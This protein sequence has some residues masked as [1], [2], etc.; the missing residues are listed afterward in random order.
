MSKP[1][2][3]SL[4]LALG[5]DCN[6]DCGFCLQLRSDKTPKLDFS[7]VEKIMAE[8]M[9]RRDVKR[10]TLTGGEPTY[11]PYLETTLKIVKLAKEL[12]KE[13]CIFTNGTLLT[14][15][16]LKEFKEAGLTRFRVSL[17]D[18][19]D[20]DSVKVLMKRFKHYGLPAMAK[21]TVTK[22]NI[23]RLMNV[24]FHIPTSG[25]EWFQI[26]PYNRVE[27][28]EV[29]EKYELSPGQ[30]RYLSEIMLVF[31]KKNTQIKIDLLP[32]CYEFLYDETIKE[33]ELSPC[34]CGQGKEG[35]LVIQPTGDVKIC[36]AYPVAL[37]N[38][39]TD[40]ITDIW[41]NHPLLTEVRTKADKPRPD[42]CK[43]C[44]HWKKCSKTDCHSATYAKHGNFDHGNPQ[45]PLVRQK[46]SQKN[47]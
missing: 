46:E 40:N 45:C 20:W 21:Y 41:N 36:G 43:D 44:G 2:L 24:L 39:K 18:E 30:V 19:I 42:D 15:E 23:S 8:E 14:E 6:L 13:T 38:V 10:L 22:E 26:K 31:R 5:Y 12:G 33:E 17:Y 25:I 37:G 27:V 47:A 29:D 16:M 35:Y 7:A 32:L 3:G 34:N 1:I 9:V 4:K 28:P 11:E